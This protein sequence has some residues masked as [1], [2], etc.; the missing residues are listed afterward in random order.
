M[1]SVSAHV[2]LVKW[3]LFEKKRNYNNKNNN[4]CSMVVKREDRLQEFLKEFYNKRER[5]R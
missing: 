1:L 5:E 3:F 2:C 4:Y